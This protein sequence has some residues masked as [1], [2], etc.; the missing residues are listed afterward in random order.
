[1]MH[2]FITFY[3]SWG[4]DVKKTVYRIFIFNGKDFA[5]LLWLPFIICRVLYWVP[6]GVTYFRTSSL[7]CNSKKDTLSW[8]I[9]LW[10]LLV[11]SCSALDIPFA[12]QLHLLL[13]NLNVKNTEI[14]ITHFPRRFTFFHFF[15]AKKTESV[16][17]MRWVYFSQLWSRC[18]DL[19]MD[20]VH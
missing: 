9:W 6:L 7:R 13:T 15:W 19:K 20:K 14:S 5:F 18:S 4:S 3:L 12:E 11:C 17:G 8:G 10:R 1:M 2:V 16:Q